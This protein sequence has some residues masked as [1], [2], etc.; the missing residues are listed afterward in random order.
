M[1]LDE[2]DFD[3]LP[4]GH[5]LFYIN[6]DVP[7]IIGRVGTIMGACNVNIAQMS[8]GRRQAGGP[9]YHLGIGRLP[10][11][12]TERNSMGREL[13]AGTHHE[14]GIMIALAA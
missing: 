1:R 3:A 14:H 13:G 7:G 6:E 9:P 11:A 5:M 2:Y 4:E 8:C 12:A 10:A